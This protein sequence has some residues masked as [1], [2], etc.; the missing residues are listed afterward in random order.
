MVTDPADAAVDVARVSRPIDV[1][2]VLDAARRVAVGRDQLAAAVV[3]AQGLRGIRMVRDLHEYASDLPESPM[4]SRTRFRV[5]EARLPAAEIQYRVLVGGRLVRLDLAWPSH[6]VGLEFD[7]EDFH[8]GDGTL[9][10]DR[11]RHNALTR[12]G[13]TMLYATATDIYRDPGLLTA[14]LADLLLLPPK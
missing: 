5:I 11:A 14:Q 2:A 9:R 1:L 4:E 3:R 7:G 8:T 10:R 6:R 13:W 12:A